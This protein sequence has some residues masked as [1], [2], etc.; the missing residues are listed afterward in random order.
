MAAL[1]VD[2]RQLFALS[3]ARNLTVGLLRA[4]GAVALATTLSPIAPLGEARNAEISTGVA[5]DSLVLLLGALATVAVT[6]A[7]GAWPAWRAGTQ[8]GPP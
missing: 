2:R 8:C 4:T 5:F 7:I 6:V 3:M 1:G